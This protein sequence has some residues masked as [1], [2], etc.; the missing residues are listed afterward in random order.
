MT[1]ERFIKKSVFSELVEYTGSNLSELAIAT[2]QFCY[3]VFKLNPFEVDGFNYV[4]IPPEAD[5][6]DYTKYIFFPY[7]TFY[8][9]I[10]GYGGMC[11]GELCL[12]LNRAEVLVNL[13]PYPAV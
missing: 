7:Q 3:E 8:M 11:S 6:A 1:T 12:H 13:E 2:G 4:E 9:P 10:G 5:P